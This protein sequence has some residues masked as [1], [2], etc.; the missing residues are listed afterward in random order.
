MKKTFLLTIAT[1][2]LIL[3]MFVLGQILVV[4][5]DEGEVY[6]QPVLPVTIF[7]PDNQQNLPNATS[8]VRTP[9]TITRNDN[10]EI[11]LTD[12]R[13]DAGVEPD[14]NNEGFYYL[15]GTLDPSLPLPPYTITYSDFDTSFT[16]SL[17]QKPLSFYRREAE[18]RLISLVKLGTSELCTLRVSVVVPNNASELYGGQNVGLS[19]CPSA[20]TLVE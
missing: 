8:S 13:E 2:V 12:F 11:L 9:L 1:A 18:N 7:P 14:V 3:T 20:V 5:V 15:A 6:E 4:G 10:T 19:F 16:I 17:W